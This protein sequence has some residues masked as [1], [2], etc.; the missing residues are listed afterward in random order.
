VAPGEMPPPNTV[1]SENGAP[2]SAT[3]MA[4]RP[5]WLTAL[6][7]LVAGILVG[8]LAYCLYHELWNGAMAASFGL[9]LVLFLEIFRLPTSV[10]HGPTARPLGGP[11]GNGPYR[12]TQAEPNRKVVESLAGLAADL[13]KSADRVPAE[14]G[15]KWKTYDDKCAEAAAA[16]GKGDHTA[17]IRQYA[18]AIRDIMRQFRNHRNPG[19]TSSFE[20]PMS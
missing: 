18:Q 13:R 16:A 10:S 6:V 4:T 19:D 2:A 12:K 7:W 17:A 20:Q 9:A 5:A 3:T 11:Y 14:A 15:V 1:P 8:V